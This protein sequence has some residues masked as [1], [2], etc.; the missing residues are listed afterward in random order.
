M[1]NMMIEMTGG[2]EYVVRDG[3]ENYDPVNLEDNYYFKCIEC[4][5]SKKFS[6]FACNPV[7]VCKDCYKKMK[8][9][10]NCYRNKWLKS[11][12]KYLPKEE[13]RYE[14]IRIPAC[15]AEMLSSPPFK[16]EEKYL[17]KYQGGRWRRVMK[18]F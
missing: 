17:Y 16:D 11:R 6:A 4:V 10:E 9:G 5:V 7:E 12:L 15:I 18:G 3:E 14:I 13:G 2:Y 8:E 1:D